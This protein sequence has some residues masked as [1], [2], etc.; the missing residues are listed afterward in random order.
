MWNHGH[1]K[2]TASLHPIPDEQ[3]LTRKELRA[4]WKTSLMT[5]KRREKAGTLQ[6]LRLGARVVRY[7]LS[8][9]R[10]LEAQAA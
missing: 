9:I 7:R 2:S 1:M 3:L 6:A 10:E 8:H 5:L 4:R